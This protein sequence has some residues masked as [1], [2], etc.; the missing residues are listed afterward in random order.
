[1]GN[2][3]KMSCVVACVLSSP[4]CHAPAPSPVAPRPPSIVTIRGAV[5]DQFYDPVAARI[6]VLGGSAS[7]LSTMTDKA[8]AFE[9]TG[10]FG[11]TSIV[12]R[13]S[14]D[15]HATGTF[16][17]SVDPAGGCSCAFSLTYTNSQPAA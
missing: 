14:A 7:G 10:P 4:A 11:G 9:L 5:G 8:G 3:S 6:E 2:L 1:M 13:I 15:H 16:T 12:L 17:V